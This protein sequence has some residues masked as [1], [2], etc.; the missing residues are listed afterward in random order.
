MSKLIGISDMSAGDK[1]VLMG[2]STN[3]GAY[4]RKLLSMGLTRGVEI[5]F[6][7]SA[8]MGDPVEIRIRGYLLSL[9]KDEAEVLQLQEV[10]E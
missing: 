6:V 4:R 3:G 7:K 5:E 2:F 1:A 9:R 10:S 8:P